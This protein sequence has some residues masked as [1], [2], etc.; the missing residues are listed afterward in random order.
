[1]VFQFDKKKFNY[2]RTLFVKWPHYNIE[3][4]KQKIIISTGSTSI[5]Y[6]LNSMS[7]QFMAKCWC[8]WLKLFTFFYCK[9]ER[10]DLGHHIHKLDLELVVQVCSANGL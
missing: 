4:F 10:D 6:I 2:I 3:N 7:K 9:F 8:G 1:M 5:S